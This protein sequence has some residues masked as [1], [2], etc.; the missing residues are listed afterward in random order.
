M[1]EHLVIT[2]TAAKELD[3][4]GDPD[5]TPVPAGSMKLVIQT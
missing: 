3:G 5:G 1:V 2:P 4:I